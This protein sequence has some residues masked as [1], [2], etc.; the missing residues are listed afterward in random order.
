VLTVGLSLERH[1]DAVA[2][3]PLQGWQPDPFGLHEMRYFSVGNP[4]KL[5]RDGRL[6]AYDE[7][8]GEAAEPTAQDADVAAS[9]P[10]AHALVGSL[11]TADVAAPIDS[12]HGPSAAAPS[13]TCSDGPDLPGTTR[14]LGAVPVDTAASRAPAQRVV[15]P[16]PRRRRREYLAVAA[17]AVVA[18]VVFVALGG[19]SSGK[20]GIAPAAFV[21]KAAQRTLA[22]TSADVTLDGSVT[23]DGHT[24]TMHGNGQVDLASNTASFKLA[25]TMAG[26]SLTETELQVGGNLYAQIAVNGHTL[27]LSGG[28]HWIELPYMQSSGRSLTTGSPASSLALLSE[29]G[30]RVVPLGASSIG[31]QT[32]DGY[33]VTPT[34]Q[35]MVASVKHESGE[36]GYSTAE[37][38]A[39][40]QAVQGMTPP[41]VTVWINPTSQLACQLT[42][43]MQFGTPTSTTPGGLQAIM[44][45]THYGTPLKVTPP[46]AADILSLQQFLTTAKA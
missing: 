22:K 21:T 31:G 27:A 36:F 34:Q 28:R 35:A 43:Y 30:A 39:V 41:T 5:V 10:L 16:Q 20:T 40:L 44:T 25:A 12:K 11:A 17:G 14:V 15:T 7:P 6:E 9:A 18:V 19:G 23:A 38:S 45:F 13:A 3:R 29:Q 32:C 4:T 37:T 1:T 33:S 8:P 46:A 42:V 24:A 26:G 2:S